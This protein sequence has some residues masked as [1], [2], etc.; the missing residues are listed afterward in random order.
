MGWLAKTSGAHQCDAF[1]LQFAELARQLQVR[2][3]VA[4]GAR[5][6]QAQH[7][8][9]RKSGVEIQIDQGDIYFSALVVLAEGRPPMRVPESFLGIVLAPVAQSVEGLIAP[10]FIQVGC[11]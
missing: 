3:L 1:R 4:V 5:H 6:A 9:G 8:H 2:N 10:R 7:L 11:N